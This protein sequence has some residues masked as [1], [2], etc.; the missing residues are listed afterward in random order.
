MSVLCAQASN[1][2]KEVIIII[3]PVVLVIIFESTFM[4]LNLPYRRLYV[5]R[6]DVLFLYFFDHLHK[7]W[8]FFQLWELI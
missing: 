1:H 6:L 8:E 4:E 3:M 7:Q 2:L 5:N